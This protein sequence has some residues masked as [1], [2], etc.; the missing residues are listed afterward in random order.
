MKGWLEE[1]TEKA[2]EIVVTTEGEEGTG[3]STFLASLIASLLES[4]L[5]DENQAD[6]GADNL[7]SRTDGIKTYIFIDAFKQ[8]LHLLDMAGQEEFWPSHDLFS[9]RGLIPVLGLLFGNGALSI[10]KVEMAMR[11]TIGRHLARVQGVTGR[12]FEVLSMVF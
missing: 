8:V 2:N 12:R 1:G 3:K 7:R 4:L 10:E 11:K 6:R 5:R 9:L